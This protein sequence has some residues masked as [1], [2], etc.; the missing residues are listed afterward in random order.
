MNSNFFPF[1]F[2]SF[3]F[4]PTIVKNFLNVELSL[5]LPQ[6]FSTLHNILVFSSTARFCISDTVSVLPQFFPF[7][8]LFVRVSFEF[9]FLLPVFPSLHVSFL[10]LFVSF[11]F[12][13]A[14]FAPLLVLCISVFGS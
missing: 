13:K 7:F 8:F 3:L 9:S 1:F 10:F 5:A 4:L 12:F 14:S 11:F 2:T 6:F